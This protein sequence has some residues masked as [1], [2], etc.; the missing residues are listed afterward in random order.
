VPHRSFWAVACDYR[1]GK[2][3]PF[4]RV[5]APTAEVADAVAA[6][7][8]IPGF[9]RPVEIRGRPYVDGGVCSASSLDLV[10]GSGLDLVIC[11]T[12]LASRHRVGGL[13]PFDRLGD[14]SRGA[15]GR[16]LG[17]E[18][19]KVRRYGTEVVFIQPDAEDL[20]VMGR[21]LMSPER[22]HLVIETAARTV[23]ERLRGPLGREL[24]GLPTGEP[25]R[26]RRPA[27]PPSTWPRLSSMRRAA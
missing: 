7:C 25:H 8:A 13:H 3:V 12:P 26:I 17:Y 11:L 4:G 18:A 16:R 5:D 21:N 27:G 19:K 1:T 2:R 9:F 23:A 6:S 14:A 22:R 15:N 20:A 10:A 24:E